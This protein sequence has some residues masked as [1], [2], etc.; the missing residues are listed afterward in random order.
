M[1]EID[2]AAVGVALVFQVVDGEDRC[3]VAQRGAAHRRVEQHGQEA[4]GPVVGMDDVGDPA[5]LQAEIQ[6]AAA[7]KGEAQ[8]VVGEVAAKSGVDLGPG[9]ELLVFE[10]VDGNLGA[11]QNGLPR[12]RPARF[13]AD[14]DAERVG[15]GVP[16]RVQAQAAVGGKDD[17]HVVTEGGEGLGE[18]ADHV[19][20]ASHFDK[21]LY[22]GRDEEDFERN[23]GA[24]GKRRAGE[25]R[26]KRRWDLNFP[27]GC[28]GRNEKTRRAKAP[29]WQTASN[30]RPGQAATSRSEAPSWRRVLSNSARRMRRRSSLSI[31]RS[32]AL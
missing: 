4:G 12:A 18:R 31:R 21:R 16:R 25:C 5:E 27:A 15:P 17:A 7:Q 29:G 11:R 28:G 2:D 13:G 30:Y 6:R 10:S 26:E 24:R 19:G 32:A 20:Q 22:F 9:E 1:G 14:V 3:G 23:H 8:V